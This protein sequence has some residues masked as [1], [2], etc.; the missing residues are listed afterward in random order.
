M[1]EQTAFNPT[2][3]NKPQKQRIW[4]LDFLRGVCVLLMIFDHTMYDIGYLFCDA[5]VATGKESIKMLVE[6]AQEYYANSELRKTVQQIVVWI[7]A[8]LCGISCSFSRSNLKRGIQATIIACI[9][10]IVTFYMDTVI[11]FG[12]LHMFAFSILLWWLIDTACCHKK[13]ITAGVCLFLGVM[14]ITM[15]EGFMSVYADNVHAFATDNSWCFLGEFMLGKPNSLNSADYYPIFPTT[16]YMLIGA[17]ISVL[18]YP[19]KKSLLPWLGKYDW[20]KPF[21]FWGRIAIWVYA[22]HQ[23]A[24]VV[25]LA[26]VS[27]IFVT[28]GDFVVI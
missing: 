27:F 2:A 24:V 10:T 6:L 25:V 12:I 18:L 26:L 7:F 20:Y 23:I 22:F 1:T 5:W 17:G 8:L 11:K 28:P 14:I 21:G 15:N 4:E 9:I 16:G 19:K 3:I 13:M